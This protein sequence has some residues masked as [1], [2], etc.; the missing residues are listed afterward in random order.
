[1]VFCCDEQ[2][3]AGQAGCVGGGDGCVAGLFIMNTVGKGR[4]GGCVVADICYGEICKDIIIVINFYCVVAGHHESPRAAGTAVCGPAAA[5]AATSVT[6]TA[7]TAPTGTA[8]VAA[9]TQPLDVGAGG[10][11]SC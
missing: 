5:A 3:K 8:A 11:E 4:L 1:M 2:G 10:G 7:A 9:G 6:S